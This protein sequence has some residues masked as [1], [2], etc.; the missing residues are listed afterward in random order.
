MSSNN[1]TTLGIVLIILSLVFFSIIKFDPDSNLNII[2]GVVLG[3]PVMFIGV[4]ILLRNFLADLAMEEEPDTNKHKDSISE[5]S[6]ILEQELENESSAS[7]CASKF[8]FRVGHALIIIGL[9]IGLGGYIPS[10]GMTTIYIVAGV[11]FGV[12]FY[13]I[14]ALVE[15]FSGINK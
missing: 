1:S 9:I 10:H 6:V 8:I 14:G 4:Y 3:A 5:N 2:I 7:V 13:M 11:I 15:F 12:I